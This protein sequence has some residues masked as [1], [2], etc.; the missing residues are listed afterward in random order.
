MSIKINHDKKNNMIEDRI[1]PITGEVL[2]VTPNVPVQDPYNINAK[3]PL[4]SPSVQN[5]AAGIY[6]TSEERQIA[7]SGAFNKVVEPDEDPQKI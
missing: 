1:D 3:K 4:F 7:V 5:T 2:Q 6:G